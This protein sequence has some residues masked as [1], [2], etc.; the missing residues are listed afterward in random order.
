VRNCPR[1]TV[2]ESYCWSIPFRLPLLLDRFFINLALLTS[3]ENVERG[4]VTRSKYSTYSCRVSVLLCPCFT[5]S[6]AMH[7]CCRV[8]V[9][10][11][12]RRVDVCHG[13]VV[14]LWFSCLSPRMYRLNLLHVML[15]PEGFNVIRSS[16]FI[17]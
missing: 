17:V 2:G 4:V 12:S 14:L 7:G 16:G 15:L 6:N 10:C 9:R 3:L 5:P 13:L 8:N 1:G 11:F